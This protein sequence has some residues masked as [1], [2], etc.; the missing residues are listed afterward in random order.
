[1][2]KSISLIPTPGARLRYYIAGAPFRAASGALAFVLV[3]GGG[4]AAWPNITTFIDG[5]FTGLH[6]TAEAS[7]PEGTISE[8]DRVSA[9]W[10]ALIEERAIARAAFDDINISVTISNDRDLIDQYNNALTRAD[11]LIENGTRDEEAL[12][13]AT[14]EIRNSVAAIEY[15]V[16][17]ADCATPDPE[18]ETAEAGGAAC[19]VG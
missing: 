11:V 14:S 19:L 10:V 6:Q 8:R 15:A 18:A 9:S 12:T 13:S 3:L 17:N 7:E 4:A 1:M 5:G 16:L 2:N